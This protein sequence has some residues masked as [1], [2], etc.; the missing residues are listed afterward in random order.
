[1]TGVSCDVLLELLDGEF[2]PGVVD[3]EFGGVVCH[4]I[5][6]EWAMVGGR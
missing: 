1:M 5:M 4:R 6:W 3:G 2:V